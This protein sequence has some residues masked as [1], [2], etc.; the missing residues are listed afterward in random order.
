M[1]I[2]TRALSSLRGLLLPLLLIAAWEYMSRQGASQAYR[3]QPIKTIRTAD[4]H[5][6]AY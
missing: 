6:P 3:S 5:C 4:M 2:L 1:K